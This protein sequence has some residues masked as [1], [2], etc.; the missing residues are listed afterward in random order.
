MVVGGE[1]PVQ[2]S[3][4]QHIT[5]GVQRGDVASFAGPSGT[6]ITMTENQ[7]GGMSV[8]AWPS[9]GDQVVDDSLLLVRQ[10]KSGKKSV[11]RISMKSSG[12][13]VSLTVT[14]E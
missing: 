3:R 2:V 4:Q 6:L 10:D 14:P 13:R 8:Q 12:D 7:D 9:S 1:S 11:Q 5:D